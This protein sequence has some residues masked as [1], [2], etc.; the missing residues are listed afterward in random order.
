MKRQPCSLVLFLLLVLAG[1][2]PRSLQA[3]EPESLEDALSRLSGDA[4]SQYLAPI[5][6]SFGSNLNTGWFSRAP[7]A[8]ILGFRLEAGLALSGAWF[9]DDADHF[10]STGSFRFSQ[11]EARF[12]VDEF[13]QQLIEE[14][15]VGL[16]AVVQDELVSQI[17]AQISEVTFSGAT[18]VG[19]AADSITIGFQLQ[20]FEVGGETWTVPGQEVKLPFGGFGDLAELSL[21]PLAAPQVSLGTLYGTS[22]TVRF[23]PSVELNEELGTFKYFGF[24]IQH[25]PMLWF[26]RKLPVDV[27]LSYFTQSMDVGTLFECTTNAFGVNASRTFGFRFLNAT[28][29]A[30]FLIEDASMKVHYDFIVETPTGNEVIPVALDLASENTTRLTLGLSL[31]AGI[32]KL[33]TD[34][35][36]AKYPAF[37]L[38]LAVA[39]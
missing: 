15:G 24:G 38:G 4:T 19:A 14:E 12:L 16:P 23:L 37:S 21:L 18:V 36:F 10:S 13:N 22:V 9:P 1:L 3:Q 8:E 17:T 20:D 6:S 5:S 30:G 34:Y 29:Y 32:I 11:N 35:S 26:D 33:N 31:R 39:F 7:K 27:A 25:N 2:A 28:P